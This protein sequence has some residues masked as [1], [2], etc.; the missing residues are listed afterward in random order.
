LDCVMVLLF[1]D[2]FQ[3]WRGCDENLSRIK[4]EF[5]L[6]LSLSRGA[7]NRYRSHEC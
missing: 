2:E 7:V 5:T 4:F 6:T 3:V 1:R